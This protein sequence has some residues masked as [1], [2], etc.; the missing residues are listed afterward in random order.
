MFTNRLWSVVTL[1][2]IAGLVLTACAPA[3]TPIVIEKEVPVEKEVVKTVVIEKEVVV[4]PTPEK[5]LKVALV[6]PT[7]ITDMSWNAAGY[8]GLMKA[9]AE[10]GVEVAYTEYIYGGPEMEATIRDYAARGYDLVIAHGFQY[11]DPIARVAKDFPN[12]YFAWGS[13]FKGGGNLAWY[14][15]PIYEGYYVVGVLA[16]LLTKTNVIGSV[17]GAPAPYTV[18]AIEAYKLGA[19]SVNPDVK[20]LT[21]YPGVWND[22]AKGKE[23]AM[24]QIEAGADFIIGVGDGITMGVIQAA[25]EKGIYAVGSFG[26]MN[27][28]APDNVITSVIWNTYPCYKK[29]IESIRNGTW[30]GEEC[31]L[32]LADGAVELAP[33][34]NLADKIP[35]EVKDKVEQTKQDII[36]GKIVVP[37][38]LEPP[39]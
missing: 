11:G 9:A 4:T 32:G 35:Q 24:A 16:G 34:Y 25:K 5:K 39:E 23:T 22:I 33:Y 13:G 18:A 7:T 31:A 2:V 38:I 3:P 28:L 37:K 26:D 30:E 19:K 17:G 15:Y 21:T 10:L 1:A 27:K 36:N 29:M 20:A 8:R 12:T 14:V 6:L